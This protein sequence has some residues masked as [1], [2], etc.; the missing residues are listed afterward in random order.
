MKVLAARYD[1][2]GEII[3]LFCSENDWDEAFKYIQI[4]GQDKLWD[5]IIVLLDFGIPEAFL[6]SL[7]DLPTDHKKIIDAGRR[8]EERKKIEII[9]RIFSSEFFFES[10]AEI[11]SFKAKI[12]IQAD[13]ELFLKF[14]Q[15]PKLVIKTFLWRIFNLFRKFFLKI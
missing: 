4:I 13:D 6:K 8:L 14:I 9:S 7:I 3:A 12:L 15:D 10:S 11:M 2:H 1:F 5:K